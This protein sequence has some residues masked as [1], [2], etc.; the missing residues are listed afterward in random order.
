MLNNHNQFPLAE[1]G[2][3]R[4]DHVRN[5]IE[6]TTTLEH[7]AVHHYENI[8][9]Q[10]CP[11]P[12]IVGITGACENVDTLF[13]V[14]NQRALPLFF[15]QTGQLMLEFALQYSQGVYTV[16]HS[17]RDEFREDARHLLEFLLI[18]EE[19][20]WPLVA[21]PDPTSN[22]DAP[23]DEEKMFSILLDR[24]ERATKEIVSRLVHRHRRVL[25]GSYQRD[26]DKFAQ[27]LNLPYLRIT[28]TEAIER[29]NKSDCS[30]RWGDDLKAEHEA[31]IVRLLNQPAPD[32]PSLPRPVFITRYPKEIKFF[33]MKV[34]SQ[35]P[36]VVLSA[37]L[38]LPF[39]GEAVGSAVREH[40]GDKLKA[41]LLESTMFKLHRERGGTYQ[42]FVWYV[43]NMIA[44][45]KTPPHAGYGLGAARL[46][47]WV[48][49]L[50][51]IRLCSPFSLMAEFTGD[52]ADDKR[53][54]GPMVSRQTTVLVS[55]AEAHKDTVLPT[56]QSIPLPVGLVLYATAGTHA[57]LAGRGIAATKVCKVGEEGQPNLGELMAKRVFDVVI[58]VPS[59]SSSN[60]ERTDGEQIRQLAF[61]HGVYVVTDHQLA[62]LTLEKLARGS[63][64]R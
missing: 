55:V 60:G 15:S 64:V 59:G 13:K 7:S 39:A 28:Y 9:L 51:D 49:G 27:V 2:V 47:Q 58:N 41:R 35:D 5:V 37:D 4:D 43:E 16:I 8:G 25:A 46:L 22:G 12:Q 19:F 6:L 53:G 18:E 57:A 38:I 44:A 17:G 42:D 52:F 10:Y 1:L 31:T 29:L 34:S 50:D 61:D 14:G 20:G 36:R 21:P 30:I 56:L 26:G 54:M 40:D 48:L 32:Q 3:G 24:I 23:Y 45:G 33:N 62:R 11:V 63:A